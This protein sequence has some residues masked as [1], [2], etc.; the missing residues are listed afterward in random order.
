MGTVAS[1]D[2]D[3]PEGPNSGLSHIRVTKA[4]NAALRELRASAPQTAQVIDAAIKSIPDTRGEP[5][6]VVGLE[7][8][9]ER[10]YLAAVPPGYDA[11]VVIYRPLEPG[12]GPQ[13]DWLVTALVNRDEYE[14]YRR[15]EMRG[16]LD[17]PTVR[18]WSARLGG[19]VATIINSDQGGT[20]YGGGPR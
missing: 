11:P 13:G 12:E 17:D 8:Q 3:P 2:A 18:V 1:A 10:K 16:I 6:R 7:P 4:V 19:T 14:E 20:R 5:V 15:A 9:Q